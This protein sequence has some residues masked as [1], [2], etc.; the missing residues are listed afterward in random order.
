MS[1]ESD[2]ANRHELEAVPVPAFVQVGLA[3]ARIRE[4]RLYRDDFATFEALLPEKV[5][6]Q[7]VLRLPPHR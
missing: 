3:L 1:S 2:P 4:A 7:T 5:A 6:L